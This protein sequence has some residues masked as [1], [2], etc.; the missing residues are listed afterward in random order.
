VK[1]RAPLPMRLYGLAVDRAAWWSLG[2]ARAMA[3]SDRPRVGYY[4]WRFPSLTGTYIYREVGALRQTGLDVEVFA[5]LRERDELLDAEARAFAA[6]T[7]YLLPLDLARLRRYRRRVLRRE[8]LAALN[9]FAYVA[10]HRYSA[11]KSPREDLRVFRQALYLAGLVLERGITH[12]HSPWAN[13]SAFIALLAARMAGVPYSVQARASA[14]LYRR[15]SL[16]GL[17][18]RFAQAKF[19]VTSSEFNRAFIERAMAHRRSVPVHVVY[20]GLDLS[21]FVPAPKRASASDPL[22]VLSVGRLSEEKGFE[23]LLQA[24]AIARE[25]G[26]AFQCV[27]VGGAD[28]TL[29]AGYDRALAELCRRLKLEDIVRFAGALPF[30]RVLQEYA[31]A[32]VFAMSSVLARDGGRDVTPNALIEAMAMQLAVVAT[33]M[34]AIPEIVE[35]RVSGI[36]VPPRNPQALAHALLELADDRALVEALGMNARK[37]V[38]QRFDVQKNACRY[39]ELFGSV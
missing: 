25:R 15:G 1:S 6:D 10:L 12:I 31:R 35:D 4:L 23:H 36:L 16:W 30:D 14:D 37:R 32:D 13:P 20:E 33:K 21:R 7:H 11:H 19:I 29:S 18:E 39:L 28:G 27:I 5:D 9:C 38:E 34:T 2:P 22:R 17:A 26:R 24:L 3:P 8:P